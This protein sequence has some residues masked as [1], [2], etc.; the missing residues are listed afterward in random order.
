MSRNKKPHTKEGADTMNATVQ[1]PCSVSESIVQSCK[2]I[3]AMR[4]GT[5]PK[6][7]WKDLREELKK[8]K[9]E[10]SK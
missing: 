3:K 4:E 5:L 10:A 7:S 2:E 9:S 8:T 1:R 6:K